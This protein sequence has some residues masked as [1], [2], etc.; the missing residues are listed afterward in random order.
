[1][2]EKRILA[3]LVLAAAM[4]AGGAT[5]AQ[6]ESG[7]TFVDPTVTM[8]RSTSVHLGSLVYVGPYATLI[9]V[10]PIHVGDESN[11]Q[12][13]VLLSARRAPVDLGEQAIMA[14][15]SAAK[16]GAVIGE[17]GSCPSG[18]RHCPSFVGFN[19]EVDGGVVERD[20]M[21]LHLARVG[22]GVRIPSG[23]KVLSGK[24][25]V[26]QSEV[27]EKSAPI[28]EADRL[29]MAGVIEV[30]VSFAKGYSAL[31]GDDPSNV[32]GINYDPG[33]TSFNPTRDLPTFAGVPTRDP[34]SRARII[35]DVRLADD[36]S[37]ARRIVLS[38][39]RAD[40]G[41]AFSVGTID[42]MSTHVT[43]HA[44]E[45]SHLELGDHGRYGA[46][47][48]VHGGPAFWAA[49]SSGDSLTLGR[50]AVLFQSHVGNGV[51][52]GNRSLVQASDL[53]DGTVIPEN[54]VVVDGVVVGTVEW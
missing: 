26:S 51:T 27:A 50:S 41:E 5:V 45:H 12:D 32:R 46:G 25:V 9:A 34:S 40:E 2:A 44:L 11:V 19:S 15:G 53:A 43:F 39:L 35:G 13:S 49:T 20:A 36:D 31:A 28:T 33:G 6:S 54:T 23:R 22:P 52:I 7:P 16:D 47:A 21:V 42:A 48:I 8:V 30:N 24:N 18:G 29:F 37:A 10:F 14:H 38:S 1:M 17:G 3:T 4:V